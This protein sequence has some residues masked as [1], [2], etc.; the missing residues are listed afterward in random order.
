M[1]KS[2]KQRKRFLK[3]YSKPENR[4]KT[5]KKS[6]QWMRNHPEWTREFRK[7]YELKPK[8]IK[9]RSEWRKKNR[10][11]VNEVRRRSYTKHRERVLEE[12]NRYFEKSGGIKKNFNGFWKKCLERDDYTCQKCFGKN[13]IHVHHKRYGNDIEL[14]DLITWCRSCHMSYHAK[15]RRKINWV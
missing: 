6:N 3:W 4:K 2:E 15:Q 5:Q 11:K 12:N 13:N 8:R 7:K 14:K 1:D 10:I 9:Y